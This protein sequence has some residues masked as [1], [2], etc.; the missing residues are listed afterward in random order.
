[1]SRH[2]PRNDVITVGLSWDDHIMYIYIRIY[3]YM[4]IYIRIYIYMLLG[5]FHL[6][7]TSRPSPGIMVFIREIIPKWPNY[8]G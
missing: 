5:I 1:M 8:S 3:I 4:Y 7:L 6:D 2:Q